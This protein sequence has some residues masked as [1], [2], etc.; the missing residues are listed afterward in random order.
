MEEG[1]E[2]SVGIS[3]IRGM[4]LGASLAGRVSRIVPVMRRE[5]LSRCQGQ[6]KGVGV[7]VDGNERL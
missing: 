2:S 7:C 6:E 4:L 5:R 3:S 1:G